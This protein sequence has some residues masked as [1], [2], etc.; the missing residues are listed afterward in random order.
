VI[1]EN[2]ESQVRINMEHLEMTRISLEQRI[3]RLDSSLG[4]RVTSLEVAFREMSR[5]FDSLVVPLEPA[6]PRSRSAWADDR[7]L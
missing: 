6:S 2:I 4:S 7:P 1:L 3:D 5:K